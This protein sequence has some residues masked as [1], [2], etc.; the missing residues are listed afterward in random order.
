MRPLGYKCSTETKGLMAEARRG[1]SN[2][3]LFICPCGNRSVPRG[4]RTRV[5][6]PCWN[7]YIRVHRIK[8]VL[9]TPKLNSVVT[10]AEQQIQYNQQHHKAKQPAAVVTA[11][12]QASVVAVVATTTKQN[13]KNHDNQDQAHNV[14]PSDDD[15]WHARG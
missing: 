1:S 2:Y 12:V 4:H 6:A 11:A 3:C 13:H 5:C 8:L 14:F 9:P 15:R 10:A 7:R